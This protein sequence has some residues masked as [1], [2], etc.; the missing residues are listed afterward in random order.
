VETIAC[1]S[2][3]SAG[4]LVVQF[5]ITSGQ[6]FAFD[7]SCLCTYYIS[8]LNRRKQRIQYVIAYYIYHL[9]MCATGEWFHAS[10]PAAFKLG[11]WH[12]SIHIQWNQGHIE[13]PKWRCTL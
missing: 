2:K 7:P 13:S 12:R 9:S 11:K 4:A 3:H 8:T 6:L 5:R 10:C 1:L